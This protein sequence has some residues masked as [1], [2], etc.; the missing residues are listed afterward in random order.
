MSSGAPVAEAPL[1]RVSVVGNSGSGKTR[2]ARTLAA[3]LDTPFLELDSVFHLP[4]WGELPVEQ[5][6]Q[7]VREFAAGPAW[8]VDGNYSVVRDLVWERADTVVWVDPPQSLVMARVV[9]RTLRRTVSRQELWNGNRE[10]FSNLW[11]LDPYRSIIAWSWTRRVEY[12][13]RYETAM[14]DPAWRHL[15]FV[16]LRRAAQARR[17]LDTARSRRLDAR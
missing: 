14:A 12:R 5:F 2:L 3:T 1:G 17:L 4:D 7:R 15:A 11:S 16:R 8:V 10:P 13:R 6:R 9:R